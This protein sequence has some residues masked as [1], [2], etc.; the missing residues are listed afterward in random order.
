MGSGPPFFF[1]IELPHPIR[2]QM[3]HV[4]RMFVFVTIDTEILPV[5]AIRWIIVM[6]MVLMMDSQLA[7][8]IAG[9]F[10][11]ASAADPGVNAQRLF[12][13]SLVP[14]IPRATRP[15]DGL[16]ESLRIPTGRGRTKINLIVHKRLLTILVIIPRYY[17]ARRGGL[18]YFDCLVGHSI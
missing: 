1:R 10:T 4:S 17:C 3:I 2:R 15:C 18:E 13:I 12:A 16:I 14:I 8:I 6:I 7:K 9:K 11:P 5:T